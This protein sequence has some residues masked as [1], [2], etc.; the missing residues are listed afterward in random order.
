LKV[1]IGSSG[2]P[3]EGHSMVLDGPVL[4]LWSKPGKNHSPLTNSP[5]LILA[6]YLHPGEIVRGSVVDGQEIYE[7][8][9]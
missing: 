5:T 9:Q 4:K 2:T 7:I 1:K 6:Y 8:T 3:V